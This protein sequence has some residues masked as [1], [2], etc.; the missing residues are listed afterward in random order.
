[1][2]MLSNMRSS[3]ALFFAGLALFVYGVQ[4]SL[5]AQEV[6]RT[7]F[8]AVALPD[9]PSSMM[10]PVETP[11]ES[12]IGFAPSATA[13]KYHRTVQPDQQAL[14]LSAGDKM[15]L[16]VVNQFSLSSLAGNLL[17]AGYGQLADSRPHYGVD[18]GAFGQRLGAASLK[19]LSQSVFSYGIYASVFHDDPR[20]YVMGPSHPFG[21]RAVYSATRIVITR[22]D[23]GSS[24]VNWS[25]LAGI[26]SAA[27]LANAYYPE[28]DRSVSKTATSTLT[29]I[30]TGAATNEL[31]EFLGDIMHK[32]HHKK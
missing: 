8:A 23:D 16:S 31:S 9:A 2:R 7:E 13:R 25:R 20:Y 26:A 28:R 19:G 18:K 27:A 5:R 14:P 4:P 10:A 12:F 21:K 29:S 11:E 24:A 30:A 1:M 22:K 3:S 15:K 17:S 32:I 6:P